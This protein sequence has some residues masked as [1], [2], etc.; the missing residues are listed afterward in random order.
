MAEDDGD[1]Y[2]E[3]KKNP[4]LAEIFHNLDEAFR[5]FFDGIE[6]AKLGNLYAAEMQFREAVRRHPDGAGYFSLAQALDLQAKS[7]YEKA[8]KLIQKQLD[9]IADEIYDG[10]LPDEYFQVPEQVQELHTL[11]LS[12]FRIFHISEAYQTFRRILSLDN[13]DVKA[14]S[15]LMRCLL[16]GGH[17]QKAE[18]VR[19]IMAGFNR[20]I[21]GKISVGKLVATM[22]MAELPS[23]KQLLTMQPYNL[24]VRW[25]GTAQEFIGRIMRT[26]QEIEGGAVEKK[27]IIEHAVFRGMPKKLAESTL[28]RMIKD[29]LAF[30]PKR[31][32][33]KMTS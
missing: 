14:W 19:R 22:T 5:P 1:G 16:I 13:E 15:G 21:E 7:A 9:E 4:D 24:M 30:V 11:A 31:G 2:E 26:Y 25:S 28:K 23:S 33:V 17:Y 3:W 8:I 27:T 10:E 20:E 32:F 29:G 6:L 18:R 12:K